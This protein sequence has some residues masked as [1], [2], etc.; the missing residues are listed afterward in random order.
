MPLQVSDDF[1][2]QWGNLGPYLKDIYTRLSALEAA[3]TTPTPAP[4][5]PAK[6]VVAASK[7]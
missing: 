3:K 1:A 5:P 6:P 4:A 7:K 2:D